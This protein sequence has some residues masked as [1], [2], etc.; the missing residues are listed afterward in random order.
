[1]RPRDRRGHRRQS[2]PG[3]AA[4]HGARL[5]RTSWS[6]P[7]IFG[8]IARLGNV[9]AAEMDRVFNLGI[10][11]VLV[12]EPSRAESVLAALREAGHDGRPIGEV[13]DRSAQRM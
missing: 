6:V 10:G 3:L 5:D 7:E 12:V 13:V 8:E 11:M 2:G 9:A 1:M 4:W